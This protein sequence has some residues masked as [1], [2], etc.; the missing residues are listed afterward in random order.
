[1]R[2]PKSADVSAG[3]RDEWRIRTTYYLL[4]TSAGLRDEWRI[5]TRD[6]EAILLTTYYLPLS[7]H[8]PLT[9]YYLLLTASTYYLLL[10]TYYLLLSK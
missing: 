6:P 1:M 4:L 10:T 3:L 8:L 2:M 7:Y 5:R 9:T